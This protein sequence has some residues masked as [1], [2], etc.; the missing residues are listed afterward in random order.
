[1]RIHRKYFV[2]CASLVT[3][4]VNAGCA[5]S[6]IS[7]SFGFTPAGKFDVASCSAACV[8]KLSVGDGERCIK[9]TR[10]MADVCFAER[11]KVVP[12]GTLVLTRDP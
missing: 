8:E 3:V 5:G 4:F 7:R 1:M 11:E 2:M 9:F 10:A 6:S 12:R